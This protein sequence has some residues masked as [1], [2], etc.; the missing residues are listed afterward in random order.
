MLQI[1]H[2]GGAAISVIAKHHQAHLQVI[3]CGTVGDSYNYAGVERHC[4]RAGTAI[5]PNRLQ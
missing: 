5:L 3:D 1:L 4:I 2:S